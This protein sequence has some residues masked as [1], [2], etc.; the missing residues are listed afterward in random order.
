MKEQ[1]KHSEFSGLIAVKD[2]QKI[3][4]TFAAIVNIRLRTVGPEGNPLTSASH[5]SNLC[6]NIITG[7]KYEPDICG[8][9]LPTFLG[10]KAVVDKNLSYICPPGFYNFIS[11]LK[12]DHKVLA[13]VVIG[14]VILVMRRSKDAY[15]YLAEELGIDLD[16][17]WKGISEIRVISFHRIQS[18]VELIRKVGEYILQ[19]AYDNMMMGK[20]VFVKA[21]ESFKQVL[22]ILLEVAIQVSGADMG[23]IMFLEKGGE[24]LTIRASKNLPERVV[25]ETRVKV[26]QGICGTA[27]K[28]DRPMLIDDK[29]SD[30]RIKSYLSRPYLKSSMVLPIKI[31]DK[32]F[33]VMNLGA[34]EV[35]SVR[36]NLDNIDSMNRIIDFTTDALYSPLKNAVENKSEY[37]EKLI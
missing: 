29:I 7:T 9:C 30:N 22:D 27:V 26:G 32:V 34:L 19:M 3:Q 36:F 14:P 11:P 37:F 15:R 17:L 12:I 6:K 16:V 2:W 23:S 18:I 21:N 1:K 35:S 24:E 4:D 31:D 10:G 8:K 25:S 13:Y 33:G 5:Q 28:E 20:D